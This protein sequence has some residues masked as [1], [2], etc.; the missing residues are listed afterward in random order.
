MS[1]EESNKEYI[2]R[3]FKDEIRGCS[4]SDLS[5]PAKYRAIAER[6]ARDSQEEMKGMD[7]LILLS[8]TRYFEPFC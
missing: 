1:N 7:R 8:R 3:K 2:I 4:A 5:D 6:M